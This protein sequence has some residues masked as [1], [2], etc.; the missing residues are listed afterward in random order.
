MLKRA[1]FEHRLHLAECWMVGDILD[2]IEAGRRA[3][4]RAVLVDRGGET[5]W[6]GGPN[7]APDAIVPRFDA[8][9]ELVLRASRSP[10]RSLSR[11][12]A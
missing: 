4:C 11:G 12:A 6:R 9:A 8:A 1:A 10:A 7:R 3:G 5:E 2:D